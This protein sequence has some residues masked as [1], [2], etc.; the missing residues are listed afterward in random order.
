[1]SDYKAWGWVPVPANAPVD[2]RAQDPGLRA[3]IEKKI[4]AHMKAR[5]YTGP[6]SSPDMF[7]N[8][9]VSTKSIGQDDVKNMYDGKYLPQYRMDFEGPAQTG[10]QEGSLLILIFDAKA[11]RM[12]WHSSASAEITD[13]APE[14]KGIERLS[15]AIKMM[16]TSLPGRATWETDN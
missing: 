9:H 8:Y 7:V 4:E 13:E 15:E 3:E 1:M 14:A 10:W 6:Q 5:G 12:V 11:E 16:F 2:P